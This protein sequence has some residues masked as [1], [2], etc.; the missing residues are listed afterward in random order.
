MG[1]GERPVLHKLHNVCRPTLHHG[2]SLAKANREVVAGACSVP[3]QMSELN[4]DVVV[5][6]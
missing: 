3:C 2:I 5:L 4:L 1:T 6:A